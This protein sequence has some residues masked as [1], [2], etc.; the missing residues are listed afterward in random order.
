MISILNFRILPFEAGGALRSKA[1]KSALFSL[2]F[3]ISRYPERYADMNYRA[4]Y[5][6]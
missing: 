5:L 2:E 3:A 6:N 4:K 1:V